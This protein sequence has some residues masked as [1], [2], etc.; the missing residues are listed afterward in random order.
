LREQFIFQFTIQL[1]WRM[2][3]Q[4]ATLEFDNGHAGR[5]WEP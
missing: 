1:F 2:H 4:I 3:P 5:E